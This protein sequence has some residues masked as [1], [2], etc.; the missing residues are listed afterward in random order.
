MQPV[1]CL[2]WK[3]CTLA[4]KLL[5]IYA[6]LSM[7]STP[8]RFA[9]FLKPFLQLASTRFGGWFFTTAT[10]PIDRWLLRRSAGRASLSGLAAPTL[11]LTTTGR[12]T[13]KPRATPLLFLEDN[14][15]LV[16]IGS[17]GGRSA[18]ASWY[19]NLLALPS[20]RRSCRWALRILRGDCGGR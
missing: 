4:D 1:V 19:L 5:P 15:R 14:G 12:R 9:D 16:V 11:L 13:G 3:T 17:R 18:Q 7:K 2:R 20:R 6:P 10:P 8:P